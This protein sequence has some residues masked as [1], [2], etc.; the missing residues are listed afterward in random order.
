MTK[1]KPEN[2]WEQF[3]DGHSPIYMTN[4]WTNNTSKEVDFIIEEL[5]L[6]NGSNIL[7]IGCGT[8]RHAIELAR[9][10]YVVTGV[11]ISRGMLAE[12]EK[13]A[14]KVGVKVK[15]IQAD[16]TRFKTAKRFDGAI[17]ICEGAF[18]LLASS[19]HPLEHEAAILRSIHT[20]LKRG[21]RLVL[22]LLNGFKMIREC[23]EAEVDSGKFDPY[24]MVE[25]H[26]MEWDTPVGKRSALVRERGFLP[27]EI[28]L[29]FGQ[30]GFH[31]EHIWGGTAGRWGKRRLEMDE[32]EMMVIA[33][34]AR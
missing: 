16:A 17:C 25:V 11:D 12:A 19:D 8:G 27:T 28:Y 9:R 29:M 32:I 3:F 10:G 15:F 34:K 5:K 33:R 1:M 30:T 22:T 26:A 24:M 23:G 31:V 18:G 2:E 6:P 13:A 4:K 7:D 14:S 21:A 20:A